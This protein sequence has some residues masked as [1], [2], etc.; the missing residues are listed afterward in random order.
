MVA[1]GIKSHPEKPWFSPCILDNY[2]SFRGTKFTHCS[3]LAV[4]L[5]LNFLLVYVGNKLLPRA[6]ISP[7]HDHLSSR[8]SRGSLLRCCNSVWIWSWSYPLWLCHPLLRPALRRA[9]E[10]EANA[11]RDRAVR[12][13]GLLSAS[14]AAGAS[15]YLSEAAGAT[16]RLWALPAE[17]YI[18]AGHFAAGD[19]REYKY[20]R[21]ITL[22]LAPRCGWDERY[23]TNCSGGDCCFCQLGAA[24]GVLT[25]TTAKVGN[26]GM[27]KTSLMEIYAELISAWWKG[28]LRAPGI[29]FKISV[30]IIFAAQQTSSAGIS[31]TSL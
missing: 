29:D 4:L 6:L 15:S 16:A 18:L 22:S 27:C 21:D 28:S 7:L 19:E 11:F 17:L 14:A 30:A 31:F 1:A 10:T 3:V 25:G 20:G 24:T 5:K 9:Q 26:L 8:V 12:Q 13:H 23:R 2:M